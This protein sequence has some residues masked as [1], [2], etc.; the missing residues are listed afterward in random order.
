M[1]YAVYENGVCT[2]VFETYDEAYDYLENVLDG[3]W[4]KCG[5]EIKEVEED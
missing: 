1:K 2:M 3:C 4:W 5:G